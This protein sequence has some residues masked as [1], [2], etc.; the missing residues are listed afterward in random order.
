MKI[1]YE[2]QH[3]AASQSERMNTTNSVSSSA[4]AEQQSSVPVSR[5]LVTWSQLT[6]LWWCYKYKVRV[7]THHLNL[8]IIVNCD[9][10]LKTVPILQFVS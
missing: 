3:Q 4:S 9:N 2:Q 5:Y 6:L 7:S 8:Q 10:P 1:E